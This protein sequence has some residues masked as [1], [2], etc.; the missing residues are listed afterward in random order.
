MK[1]KRI[2]QK[3]IANILGLS[4][5]AISMSLRN[6]PQIPLKTR[7]KVQNKAKEL[8]YIPDPSLRALAD[9]RTLNREVTKR[10]NTVAFLY[11]WETEKEWEKNDFY[12]SLLNHLKNAA[13]T[14]GISVEVHWLG[15]Q[16]E[17]TQDV[18]NLLRNRG[19]TGVFL[20]PPP[21]TQTASEVRIKLPFE[22]FQIVTFGPES[23]Y[24][25][26]HTV[27]F[28]FYEN[29]RLAW[30]TLWQRGYRKIGH[31]FNKAHG[32]RTGHAWE[33]AF[34]IEKIF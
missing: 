8:N 29:F 27:Q 5:Q 16:G 3:F 14:R 12:Q 9:Y 11:N 26:F 30:K 24:P 33:A 18:C 22:H 25:D 15:G 19:I 20:S 23:L 31:V 6:H 2:T 21:P 32:W 17:F 13:V 4:T 28:D 7:K 1:H 10:W 34:Y